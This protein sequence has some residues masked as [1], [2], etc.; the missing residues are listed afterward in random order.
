MYFGR[1]RLRISVTGCFCG[2]DAR[3]SDT[4]STVS[5][6]WSKYK[7]T[8]CNQRP[9]LILSLSSTGLLSEGEF[10]FM[11]DVRRQYH[12]K[13]KGFPCLLLSV[14][15]G[16]D[17][18]VQ[19]VS[20]QVTISHP[21]GCRLPLLSARPA[22]TFPAAEHHRPLASTKFYC[23]VTEAHRFEQLAQGCYAASAPS[24]IWTQDLLIASPMLYPLP[25]R[26]RACTIGMNLLFLFLFDTDKV[27]NQ[28]YPTQLLCGVV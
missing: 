27:N 19:A 10:A 8:D 11:P 5:K 14:G 16:A 3:L 15:P 24:R 6:H 1:E 25:L 23:L 21:P 20:P 28:S 13:G 22:M 18:G 12:K 17:P 2:S 9:G 7:S 26:H 4:Q